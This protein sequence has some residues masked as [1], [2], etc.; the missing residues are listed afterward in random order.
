MRPG[1]LP[2]RPPWPS[3]HLPLPLRAAIGSFPPTAPSVIPVNGCRP[4][5]RS[6][7]APLGGVRGIY[8]HGCIC[9]MHARTHN[10]Y[11]CRT[12]YVGHMHAA[13]TRK[14]CVRT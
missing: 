12:Y 14:A 2:G 10:T 4:D 5:C 1:G 11:V 13:L 9:K 6:G 3:R 7:Q 8:G